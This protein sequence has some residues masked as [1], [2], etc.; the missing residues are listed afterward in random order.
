MKLTDEPPMD[1]VYSVE[2]GMTNRRYDY[3]FECTKVVERL[4][5]RIE[6]LD[7]WEGIRKEWHNRTLQELQKILGDI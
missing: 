3:L 5:K 2:V 6:Y 4:K 7:A 1:I